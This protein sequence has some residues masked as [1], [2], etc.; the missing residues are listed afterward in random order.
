PKSSNE[1]YVHSDAPKKM[2]VPL[3]PNNGSNQKQQFADQIAQ[4]GVDGLLN[5]LTQRN[6]Q[7]STGQLARG[8]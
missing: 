7:L 1:P 2:L 8:A 4:H 3:M 5:F 6:Q